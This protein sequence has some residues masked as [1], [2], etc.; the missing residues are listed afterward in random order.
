MKIILRE[1]TYDF[2]YPIVLP[3]ENELVK[4]IIG[5]KHI[6]L[7]HTGVEILM[8]NLREK[9]WILGGRK[10]IRTVMSKCG[11]CR[12]YDSKSF[13]TE[14]ASLPINSAR[15][16]SVFEVVDVDFAAPI[17]LKGG[18]K[19]WICIFTCAVFRAVSFE[20]VT[21]LSTAAFFMALRRHIE[22]RGKP[23]IIYGDNGKNFTVL[24]NLLKNIK[25]EKVA[26]AIANHQIKWIYNLPRAAWWGGFC[27]RLIGVLKRLLRRTL[28]K[29]CLDYEEMATVLIDCEAVINSKLL[30]FMSDTAQQI[31]EIGVLDLHMIESNKFKNR[32]VYQQ[33]IKDALR[34]RFRN[35]YLGTLVHNNKNRERHFK[36]NIDDV[37]F[38]QNENTKR[39]DWP[40]AR[41]TELIRGK[42]G[43]VRVVRLRTA[44][45]E[46]IRPIQRIYPLEC[47]FGLQNDQEF[48]VNEYKASESKNTNHVCVCVC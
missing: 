40:L 9:Y 1:D 35:E 8:S 13:T 4:S 38:V 20:L 26:S 33:K 14:P 44:N 30:T 11:V 15:E 17:V 16:A 24:N 2:R 5:E 28:K 21:S 6:E 12:R 32:Y 41:V 3:A 45:G 7:K 36:V 18:Q 43:N 48:R 46:L 22:R 42:D 25:F 39:L 34:R 29:S 31:K 19:S 27:E 47:N 37:V 23:S 10:I